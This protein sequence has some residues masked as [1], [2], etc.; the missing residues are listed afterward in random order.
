M[1]HPARF[2]R[3]LPPSGPAVGARSRAPQRL[4]AGTAPSQPRHARF[5]EHCRRRARGVPQDVQQ[6]SYGR[7]PV[8]ASCASRNCCR[9]PDKRRVYA[10]M[11]SR[12]GFAEDVKPGSAGATTAVPREH[13][14]CACA[15]AT[16]QWAPHLKRVS[17]SCA[18]FVGA[19]YHALGLVELPGPAP[20][21]RATLQLLPSD[22][23]EDSDD[24]VTGV[25]WMLR[26]ANRD[27]ELGGGPQGAGFRLLPEAPLLV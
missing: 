4:L 21:W 7:L 5:A 2:D 1:P 26:A 23:T 6:C 15:R 16:D 10:A 13:C 11:E 20:H 25:Q 3:V 12:A 27:E 14:P 24:M 9:A 8:V 22:F 19:C 17:F 18:S